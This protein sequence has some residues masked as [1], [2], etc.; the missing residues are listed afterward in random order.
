[1]C[2]FLAYK[3]APITLDKLLYQPKN[4]LIRQ[5]YKAQERPEPLNGDGFGVG[6]YVPELDPEPA[7]FVSTTP[8][9]NN[10]NLRYNAPKLRSNCIFAHVRAASVGDVSEANCHP[11]HYKQ[12]LFMHN[13]NVGGFRAIKRHLRNRLSD[14]LYNWIQGQTDSEHFFALFL[15]NLL[16]Q[17]TAKSANAAVAALEATI[18]EL[19]EITGQHGIKEPAHLNVVLTEG[20]WMVASRYVTDPALTPPT[21]YHSEGSHF[22]C[23]NGVC[24]MHRTD[25]AEH[26]VL[27]VSEK[28]T[29]AQEDW[30]KVPPNHVVMV[31]QDLAV[32]VLPIKI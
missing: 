21:L 20:N 23:E 6:W 26:A 1:M 17:E 16:K 12:F 22:E 28:L 2:R 32:S 18:T 13:G 3:G 30:H 25:P 29:E 27:I 7:V 8:A 15:N 10:R 5:S 14:E 9:W 4:S 31:N 24:R 19:I 11:F